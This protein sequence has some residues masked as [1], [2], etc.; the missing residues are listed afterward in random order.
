MPRCG[1]KRDVFD[2]PERKKGPGG[3]GRDD[4][5]MGWR[6]VYCDERKDDVHLRQARL[7]EQI[8]AM[9]NGSVPWFSGPGRQ[10]WAGYWKRG[11][12]R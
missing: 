1:L 3:P 2:P 7:L 12:Y 4:P 11:G 9:S 5:L 10:P 6:E 8:I